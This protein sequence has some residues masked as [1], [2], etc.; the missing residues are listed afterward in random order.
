MEAGMIEFEERGAIAFIR[1]NNGCT[2]I[3]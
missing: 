2:V 1:F 3:Y